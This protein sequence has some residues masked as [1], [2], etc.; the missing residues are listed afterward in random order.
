LLN[1]FGLLSTGGTPADMVERLNALTV[2]AL[3]EPKTAETLDKQGIV[4]RTM[5]P[6]EFKSFVAAETEKFGKIVKMANITLAN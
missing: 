4:P 5:S 6:A 3:A 1:W 2:K